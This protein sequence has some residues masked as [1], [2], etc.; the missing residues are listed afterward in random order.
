MFS[1]SASSMGLSPSGR[2]T[3]R[4]RRGD[5]WVHSA[6]LIEGQISSDMIPFHK[7]SQWLC[8]TLIEA[9]ELSGLKVT[10][11]GALTGLPEY[12]NGGL[13]I[14]TGALKL[15]DPRYQSERTWSVGS[16]LAVE[17]RAL[18]VIL[19]DELAARVRKHYGKTE[20]ELPLSNIL[21]GGTW[22]AGR[23]YA[24]R[25]RK[26]GSPPLKIRLDG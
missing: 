21:E 8:N 10:D 12:R 5:M 20:K 1:G 19:L 14:D 6:F 24:K 4:V 7:L 9:I 16:E 22:R 13:L 2:S 3:C 23:R 18:T 15:K 26:D 17:W 11:L 25:L